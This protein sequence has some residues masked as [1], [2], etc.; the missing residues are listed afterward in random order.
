MKTFHYTIKGLVQGVAFRHYTRKS[1]DQ[2][3]ILGTVKNLYNGD[4]EVYAQGEAGNL[5]RF[6][7]FLNSGPPGAHVQQVIKE[8]L[9]MNHCFSRFEIIF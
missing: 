3:R 6:E 8:E 5:Q 9:E 4:V 2:H 1:A 7:H